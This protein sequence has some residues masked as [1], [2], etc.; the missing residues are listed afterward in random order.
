MIMTKDHNR[1]K[2]KKIII[3]TVRKQKVRVKIIFLFNLVVEGGCAATSIHIYS[4][5]PKT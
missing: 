1:T 5:S 3:T 4:Y 2:R